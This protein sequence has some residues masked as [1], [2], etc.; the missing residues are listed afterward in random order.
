ML[1][2]T[3][4]GNYM[5]IKVKEKWYLM[6]KWINNKLNKQKNGIKVFLKLYFHYI[7]I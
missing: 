1:N 5:Q 2:H 4:I 6:L 3:W 7:K